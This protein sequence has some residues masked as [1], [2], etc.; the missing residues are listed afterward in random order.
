MIQLKKGLQP[1]GW[2]P[3]GW[4]PFTFT[5]LA[6]LF[7]FLSSHA[8]HITVQGNVSGEWNADTIFVT[9]DLLI[10]DGQNLLIQPGT[11]VQFL[12]SFAFNVQGSVNASGYL[13]DSIYFQV[14]D[15]TGFHIDSIPDGGWKGIKFDHNRNSNS[16]SVFY[17]CRFSFGKMVSDDPLSGNG[18][19]IS[20]KAFDKVQIDECRFAG[21]YAT[22]NGGAVYLDSADIS[23]FRSGFENNRCGLSV[24]P[25]GYGGAV[26]ADNSSPEIRWNVFKGNASTGIGGALSVRYKDC[27]VY[28]NVFTGNFSAL[29]GALGVL[30]I[31]E[32][33]HRISNNL[34][35]ANTA[36][37]FGGGIATINASPVYINNTIADNS[38]TYGGGFYCKDSIS[39]AFHNTIIWGNMAAVGPQGYLFEVFSQA[40]FYSCDVQGGPSLF[41]GSGGGEA[42]S[43]AFENCLDTLPGF[44][45]FTEYPYSLSSQSPCIDAGSADTTGFMLPSADLAGNPRVSHGVIDMGAYEFLFVGVKERPGDAATLKAWPN[46]TEGKFKVQSLKFKEEMVKFKVEVEIVELIDH[47]GRV[48][49]VKEMSGDA[50]EV[51]IDISHLPDGV[52]LVRIIDGQRHISEKIIKISR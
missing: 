50:G 44:L 8:D 7:L 12:G 17:R 40:D 23:I 9:G 10:P 20:V 39:P 37:Y 19:A 45:D 21:N 49:E 43:G 42:F 25:W 18:G 5:I 32:I 47:S 46:P 26:C 51:E 22:F 1:P 33:N 11:V 38:A 4:S 14:A 34:F 30:H 27:M 2:S 15:T 36:L 24:A 52:Y 41:G 16:T 3:A 48:W 13:N 28:N 35:A 6:A 31:P 29:G